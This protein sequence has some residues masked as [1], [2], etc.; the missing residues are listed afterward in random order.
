MAIVTPFLTSP[1]LRA[2]RKT[3][4]RVMGC[5]LAFLLPLYRNWF[6]WFF[7]PR[8]LFASPVDPYQ[9]P[10]ELVQIVGEDR[11]GAGHLQRVPQTFLGLVESIFVRLQGA[12]DAFGL[13]ALAS[14]R[15]ADGLGNAPRPV[16][17]GL[18]ADLFDALAGQGS[19]GR[20]GRATPVVDQ[21][22]GRGVRTK[23][24][25]VSRQRL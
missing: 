2:C 1:V 14:D 17:L 8:A 13:A 21:Q 25:A 15:R 3:P 4:L 11:P 6:L 16:A 5:L 22:R 12:N 9:I 24:R 23:D 20:G 10:H 19:Q 7:L 18:D